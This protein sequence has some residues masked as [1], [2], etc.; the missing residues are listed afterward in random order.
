MQIHTLK[1]KKLKPKKRIGRGGKRGTYS[2]KG[3]KGQKCRAGYKL[4]PQMKDVIKKFH[5]LRGYK[6]NSYGEDVVTF[7]LAIL[8]KNFKEGEYVSFK[9]LLDKGLVGKI[10]GKQPVIKIL[11]KG[12]LTKHLKFDGVTLSQ[13]VK[14]KLDKLKQ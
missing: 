1:A 7:N 13:T 6:L 3:I 12:E 5:K 2:G 8:E 10:K 11:G 14:D 4:Q 9:T